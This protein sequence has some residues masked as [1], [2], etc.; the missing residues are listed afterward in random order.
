VVVLASSAGDD[1]TAALT[2]I[3]RYHRKP[4]TFDEV[5]KAIDKDGSGVLNESDAVESAER[6]CLLIRDLGKPLK[7]EEVLQNLQVAQSRAERV[8]CS[9]SR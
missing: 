3:L 6:F 2:M 1:A 7:F 9:R 8:R 4:V 5:R